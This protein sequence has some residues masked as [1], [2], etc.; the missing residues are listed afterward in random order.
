MIQ[1]AA[2][3]LG[4]A[5]SPREVAQ[6]RLQMGAE[7][8]SRSEMTSL[9]K[10]LDPSTSSFFQGLLSWLQKDW[11]RSCLREAETGLPVCSPPLPLISPP[12]SPLCPISLI[13]SFP[14]PSF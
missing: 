4:P 14:S 11:G 5:P 1:D 2:G 3:P 6:V 10:C 12:L 7:A 13:L 9:T 8:G